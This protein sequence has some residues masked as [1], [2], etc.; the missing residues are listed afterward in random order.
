MTD[1]DNASTEGKIPRR[2]NSLVDK[3]GKHFF[4]CA[5]LLPILP[6]LIVDA[7]L[8]EHTALGVVLV[9]VTAA[10]LP[11]CTP[12]PNAESDFVRA[13]RVTAAA[14]SDPQER[15]RDELGEFMVYFE[16]T[17]PQS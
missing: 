14:A 7:I 4:A 5:C 3:Y 10:V 9:L 12:S 16:R 17:V 6:L 1:E 15:L 2:Q 11:S 8:N 13:A